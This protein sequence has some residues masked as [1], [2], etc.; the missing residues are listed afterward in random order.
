LGALFA[1]AHPSRVFA[2]VLHGTG[3]R[4]LRAPDYPWEWSA[5]QW[6]EYLGDIDRHWGTQDMADRLA[7]SS[8]PSH[9]TDAGFRRELASFLRF[10]ASPG[11]ALVSETLYRDVD[12]RGGLRAG[13]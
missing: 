9:A 13:R 6:D 12:I 7:A 5:Q 10:S 11:A 8:Y 4:G 3:A 2:C 1:P